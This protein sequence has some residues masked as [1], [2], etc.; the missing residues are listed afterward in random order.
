MSI[1]NKLMEFLD[2]S[3]SNFHAVNEMAMILDEQGFTHLENNQAWDL[4]AKAKYYVK[5]NNSSIFAFDLSDYQAGMGY[6][7]VA[8][9][10]DAPT[11]KVK[12]NAVKIVN[13][14]I[15]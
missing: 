5:V 8:S 7:I 10:T 9:H 6:K 12:P 14:Y 4:S 3:H 11:F 1:N 13:N 2:K 15:H